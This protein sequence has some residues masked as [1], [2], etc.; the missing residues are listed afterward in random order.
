M[1]SLKSSKDYPQNYIIKTSNKINLDLILEEEINIKR[2][3]ASIM[4][5]TGTV[6]N[7]VKKLNTMRSNK[8]RKAIAEYNKILKT[9]H[10]LK[11][12]NSLKYRQN[13]QIALNRGESYH[14]LAGN[15]SYANSSKIIAKTER[16]QLIY[17][18]C[19]RL[20]C[21][22]II[23]YNSYILSK[24]YLEKQKLNQNNQIDALKRISPIAWQHINLYGKYEFDKLSI[25][26]SF[27]KLNDII[28]DDI[29]IEENLCEIS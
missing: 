28:K 22:V 12:I 4:L 14:Q 18:E 23:Y 9:I 16:K 6:S 29:L 7:I 3:A 20:I 5:K 2:I 26:L 19:T 17:K 1:H 8:T 13:I 25:P 10:I 11:F 27:N 21:N 24:F 15:V